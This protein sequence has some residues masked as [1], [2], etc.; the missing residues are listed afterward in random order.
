MPLT[1]PP[2][3]LATDQPA[4]LA[5]DMISHLEAIARF[6]M[7]CALDAEAYQL[8]RAVIL[9][10]LRPLPSDADP[11]PDIA[12]AIDRELHQIRP[13]RLLAAEL[14]SIGEYAAESAALLGLFTPAAVMDEQMAAMDATPSRHKKSPTNAMTF[15]NRPALG[16]EITTRAHIH[17]ALSRTPERAQRNW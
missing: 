16:P 4:P 11:A 15:R 14:I 2:P 7:I 10:G 1:Q 5:H 8:E 13:G 9:G 6:Y 3:A 12:R 17:L